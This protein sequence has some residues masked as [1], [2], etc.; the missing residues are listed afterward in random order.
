[1]TSFIM[2]AT[3]WFGLF[4]TIIWVCWPEVHTLFEKLVVVAG[5][6]SMSGL[7][8]VVALGIGTDL[9]KNKD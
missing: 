8:T 9:F 3:V 7:F 2:L 6:A 4:P 5:A 1:M